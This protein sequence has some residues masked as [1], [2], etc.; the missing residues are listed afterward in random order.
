LLRTADKTGQPEKELN[1]NNTDKY[2]IA[3]R[4]AAKKLGFFIHAIVYVATIALLV[5]INL[6]TSPN[7][8]WFIWPMAGWGIGLFVHGITIFLQSG[9]SSIRE[10]MVQREIELL[11]KQ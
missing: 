7:Y 2:K 1:M 9:S 3:K 6:V 11:E 8:L 4:T 5:N 10:R